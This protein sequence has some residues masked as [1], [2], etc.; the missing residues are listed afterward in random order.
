M[1]KRMIVAFAIL[2]GL[3]AAM[4]LATGAGATPAAA[5]EAHTS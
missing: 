4:V 1:L 2:A 5:C 3:S